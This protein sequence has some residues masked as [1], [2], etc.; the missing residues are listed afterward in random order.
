MAWMQRARPLP[1]FAVMAILPAFGAPISPLLLLAGA[2]F[3]V[4]LGLVGSLLA[5]AVNVT[6]CYFLAHLLRPW[7]S[8]L[9]R[10]SRYNLPNFRDK[11]RGVWRFTL[12]VKL[13][14]GVPAFVKQYGLGI[15]GVP[16]G[17]YFAMSML[18]T[19]AYAV[20]LVVLG[21]SLF[22]HNRNRA[23]VAGAIVGLLVIAVWWWRRR[24]AAREELA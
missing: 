7:I 2:T 11:E 22:E 21:E 13:A 24:A 19:G 23:L 4:R 9:L 3:G 10:R 12:A 1:F 8:S 16:F 18:I 5:L 14:P 6:G 20:S 17:I 15:A